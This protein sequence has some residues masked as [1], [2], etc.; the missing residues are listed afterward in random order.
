[1]IYTL[2]GN[3]FM[4]KQELNEIVRTFQSKH[5]SLAVERL[6]AE[7]ASHEHII[8]AIG[9]LS[10]FDDS[11]LVV[12]RN[13]ISDKI[14]MDDIESCLAGVPETTTVVLVASKVDKRASAYKHLQK[15]TEYR[16][17]TQANERDIGS[18]ITEFTKQKGGNIDKVAANTLAMRIGTDQT[19]LSNE[20]NKLIAHDPHITVQSVELLCEPL[21]QSTTFQLLDVAFAGN[22]KK[23]QELYDDQRKQRV[24]PLA[25][26]GM[27]AWQLHVLALIKFAKGKTAGEIAKES[28]IS[29]FVINKSVQIAKKATATQ[30]ARLIYRTLQ[31]DIQLKTKS[32]DADEAL[33]HYLL[34]LPSA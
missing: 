4:L 24:E 27:V 16:E 12:V 7:E 13:F 1:M 17:F 15:L 9:N 11:K 22:I 5:D 33:R 18:W 10:M 30:L 21:P 14:L 31:L 28:K 29:P 26:L 3:D 6:D 8:D 32:V 2:T 25:I 34:S 23:A 19:L 20:I